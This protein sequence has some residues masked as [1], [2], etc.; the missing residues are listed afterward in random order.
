MKLFNQIFKTSRLNNFSTHVEHGCLEDRS[1]KTQI[2]EEIKREGTEEEF[3]F[4][5]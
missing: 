1:K 4:L 5:L 3:D 2:K